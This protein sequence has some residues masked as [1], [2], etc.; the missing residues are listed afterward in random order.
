[1]S[2]HDGT[3]SVLSMYNPPNTG[4]SIAAVPG[5]IYATGSIISNAHMGTCLT[6]DHP[7]NFTY[8]TAL[9]TAD[10]GLVDP[11]TTPAVA[12]PDPRRNGAVLVVPHDARSDEHTVPR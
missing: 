4:F 3:V 1:M 11:A 9:A 10:G 2:C 7:V 12:A 8:D 6:D 5:R